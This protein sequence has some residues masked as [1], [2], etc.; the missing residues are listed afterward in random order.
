MKVS[1]IAFVL[2][3]AGSAIAAPSSEQNP[4]DT[5]SDALASIKRDLTGSGFTHL[6]SDNVLRSFDGRMNVVDHL[7]LAKRAEPRA[8]SADILEEVRTARARSFEQTSKPRSIN[9][10]EN[11]QESCVSENCPNDAFCQ[12]L[13]IYGYNCTYCLLVTDTIGNCQTL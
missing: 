6:G 2:A 12:G 4:R 5:I 7:S 3:V 8:P 1:S 10:L 9:V 11:R 13:S